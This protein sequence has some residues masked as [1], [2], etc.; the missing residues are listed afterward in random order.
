[1]NE[2][3]PQTKTADLLALTAPYDNPYQGKAPRI[4][5][6][7][8]VGLL[9]SPTAAAYFSERGYNTRACG[10]MVGCA[11]IPISANLVE[12][13]FQIAFMTHENKQ[14]TLALFD[15][16]AV[17][18]ERISAKSVVLNICDDYDFRQPELMAEL[19]SVAHRILPVDYRQ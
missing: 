10:S 3:K 19:E 9:R 5:F 6:V 11:L 18:Q 16:D 12:W 8:S 1:M 7:C 13:A 2:I 14:E 4:L 17:T 15:G